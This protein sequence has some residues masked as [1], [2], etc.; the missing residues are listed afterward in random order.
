MH[1]ATYE[2]DVIFN[3]VKKEKKVQ[4]VKTWI[5]SSR[6]ERIRMAEPWIQFVLGRTFDGV[7]LQQRS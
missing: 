4:K 2:I 5:I 6:S 3:F 1:T 7:F